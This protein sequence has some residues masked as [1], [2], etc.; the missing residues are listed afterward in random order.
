MSVVTAQGWAVQRADGYVVADFE[1]GITEAKIWQIALG[2]PP[3]D[4]I[5]W[6]KANG[7]R[8][9]RCELREVEP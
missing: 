7:T 2:W 3:E 1:P 5:A 8:A 9:F 6:H 4:E